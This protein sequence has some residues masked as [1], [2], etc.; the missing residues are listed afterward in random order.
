MFKL[1]QIKSTIHGQKIII[2]ITIPI[3]ERERFHL[4]KASPIPT[5]ANS[6]YL[7]PFVH[8]TYFLMNVE[9]TKYVPMN[10]KQLDG[11]RMMSSNEMLYQPT[12]TTLLTSNGICEWQVLSG[13]TASELQEACQFTPFL[14][15]NVIMTVIE[16][17][18]IFVNSHRNSSIFE[19][20]NGTE[21]TQRKIFGRGTIEID[22]NCLFKT[23][24]YI[25]RPHK[26][27]IVEG[28]QIILPTI[29]LNEMELINFTGEIYKKTAIE[30]RPHHR[31]NSYTK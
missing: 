18:I 29:I 7:I 26:T 6:S 17:E 3:V 9:Q 27:K 8:S 2:E 16:N 14:H 23:G 1:S 11:G 30:I 12:N 15:K 4:Y 25:I 20:C 5:T 10:Q 13:A 21:Y 22:S 31:N 19:A 24:N 28:S